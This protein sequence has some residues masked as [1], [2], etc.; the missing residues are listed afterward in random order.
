MFPLLELC[1]RKIWQ[2]MLSLKTREINLHEIKRPQNR[3][4]PRALRYVRVPV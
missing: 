2:E 3:A 1:W 4:R